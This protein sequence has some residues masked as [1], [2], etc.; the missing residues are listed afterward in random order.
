MAATAR[1][2]VAAT[3]FVLARL[4]DSVRVQPSD[5]RKARAD[6]VADEL[7]KKYANKVVHQLG[8]CICLFDLVSVGDPLV[9]P[10]DGCIHS[11][12]P[13]RARH[14]APAASGSHATL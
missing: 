3:M 10:G 13:Q 2:N 14:M 12:G 1:V 11:K 8:L 6:A 9:V 5:F 4:T 7:N